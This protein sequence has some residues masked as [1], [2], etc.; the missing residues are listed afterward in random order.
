MKIE[1][2][3]V[4]DRVSERYDVLLEPAADLNGHAPDG[5]PITTTTRSWPFGRFAQWLGTTLRARRNRMALLEL[6]DDQLKDIGISRSQA[7][8]DH[9]RYRRSTAHDLER[10]CL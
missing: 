9:S 1:N 5:D 10:K 7:Y 3:A 6:T 8:G 2:R 4:F